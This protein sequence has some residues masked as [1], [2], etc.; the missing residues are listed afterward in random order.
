MSTRTDPKFTQRAIAARAAGKTLASA[1]TDQKNEFLM[2]LASDLEA[3]IQEIVL[4]N[5]MD[6]AAADSN[7]LGDHIIDRLKLDADRIKKIA[8]DVRHVASLDD[9]VR[10]QIESFTRPNGLK[11]ERVRVPL[12][13]IGVIYESRPNVTVDIAALCLKSGN[14]VVLRGGREAIN[15]NKVLAWIA[16]NALESSGLPSDAIQFIDTTDRAIVDE[17]L[18]AR[19]LIDLLIP[20]GGE[21]LINRVR[22]DARVPAI[23]GGIGVCH[24]YVDVDADLEKA[25]SIVV[26]AKTQRPSVCNALDTL[27]IHEQVAPNYLPTIAHQLADRGVELRCDRRSLA[28]LEPVLGGDHLK[29]AED[30]DYGQEF[31]A[32]VAAVKVVDSMDDA[33]AHIDEFGSGHSEAIVT[34][35]E[36]TSERFLSTVDAAAVFSNASTYFHD[37]GEFGLGAE[38]AVSTDRLH[39]R[40]PL[41]LREITTYK[42]VVRGD[43]QVR[44]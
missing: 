13:V 20:R 44:N 10:E 32:L 43:G 1:S 28:I 38:V 36:E 30:E 37:G 14:T 26:N 16:R 33:F 2:S 35:D 3:R 22:E 23:T 8:T 40:G 7:G 12:G 5:D 34:E 42:W 25:I 31:L 18:K 11:I 24:T 17:M 27:L 21:T 6:V 41:G 4:A 15:S 39:A 29:A 19:G 9:P